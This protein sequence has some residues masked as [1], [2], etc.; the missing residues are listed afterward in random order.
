VRRDLVENIRVADSR[1]CAAVVPTYAS[2]IA[3]PIPEFRSYIDDRNIARSA[4]TG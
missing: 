2:P 3:E 1:D 4:A